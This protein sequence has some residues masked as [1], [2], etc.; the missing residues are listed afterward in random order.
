M[1]PLDSRHFVPSLTHVPRL[2][3]TGDMFFAFPPVVKSQEVGAL[4]YSEVLEI[5]EVFYASVSR[6]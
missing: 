1:G 4:V 2:A 5:V 3:N 6:G